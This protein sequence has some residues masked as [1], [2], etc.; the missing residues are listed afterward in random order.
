MINLQLLS[1]SFKYHSKHKISIVIMME[2]QTAIDWPVLWQSPIVVNTEFPLW[3]P[4]SG[5]LGITLHHLKTETIPSLKPFAW[6]PAVMFS[7]FPT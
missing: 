1:G 5:L 6:F 2:L 7:F 4:L 3:K